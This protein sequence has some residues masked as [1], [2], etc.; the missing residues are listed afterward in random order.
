MRRFRSGRLPVRRTVLPFRTEQQRTR[1]NSKTDV[2]PAA[3]RASMSPQQ[4]Y[5]KVTEG[6]GMTWIVGMEGLFGYGIG[7]SDIRV[8]LADGTERDCLQKIY[9]VGRFIAAGFAGSVSIGFAMI[10]RLTELL[11]SGNASSAWDPIAVAEWWPQDARDIFNRFPESERHLASHLMLISAHPTENSGDSPWPRS[12]VHTFCSPDFE[13]T[14]V[15]APEVAAIGCGTQFEPCRAAVHSL[16][17]D[18][19]ERLLIMQAEQGCSGGMATLLAFRLTVLLR[20]S[21][22]SGISSH[23]HCCWVYRGKV[24]IAPM[25]YAARGR[26]S[27]FNTGVEAAEKALREL[28]TA[29]EKAL[30]SPGMDYFTMPRVA[31]SRRDLDRMLSGTGLSLVGATC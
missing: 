12:Y 5:E 9:N 17:N 29:G 4:W 21:R 13:A 18:H 6:L 23:L 22:P 7:V 25:N 31:K 10:E 24:V 3:G 15:Q 19:Q 20:D 11:Y 8:T 26:W 16:S 30:N 2:M 1:E 28:E 14:R 27:T